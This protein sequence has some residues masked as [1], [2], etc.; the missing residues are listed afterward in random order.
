MIGIFSVLAVGLFFH[1]VFFK[2][3]LYSRAAA[4]G[5]KV[6][7]TKNSTAFVVS[8]RYAGAPGAVTQARVRVYSLNLYFTGNLGVINY[9][10]GVV[11]QGLGQTTAPPP[12]E[13]KIKIVG[14]SQDPGGTLLTSDK[15]TPIVTISY[16]GNA[17]LGGD[18]GSFVTIGADSALSEIPVTFA[19]SQTCD[20]S[21]GDADCNGI[22][23]M[24]DFEIWRKEYM[25]NLT[26]T[27]ADFN[28][29]A[30]VSMPDFEIWRSNYFKQLQG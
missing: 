18:S 28:A 26:T 15:D 27:N 30:K 19:G 24:V 29:D 12:P 21:T 25:G 23:D 8:A 7:I 6:T 3:R 13:A 9:N 11:S 1:L 4:E 17:S 10:L 2:M 20:K 14:E 5:V 22:I 16:T